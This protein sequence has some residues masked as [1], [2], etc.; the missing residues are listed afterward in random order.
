MLRRVLETSRVGQ[1]TLKEVPLLKGNDPISEAAAQMRAQSH[2]SALICQDGRL[3]GVFTE[4]DLLKCIASGKAMTSPVSSVMTANPQTVTPDDTLLSV[5]RHMDQGGYRRL[6]VTD[7]EGRPEG[8]VDVKTV[9]HFLV[10]HF[11]S[12]VYNQASHAQQT[13]KDREGA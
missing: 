10:E 11:P 13:A 4:R 3:T 12:A 5:I 6:P 7:A 8:I 9:V 1:L 2:G